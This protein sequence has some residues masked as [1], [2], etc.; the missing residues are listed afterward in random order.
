MNP[1]VYVIDGARTPYLKAREE[2]GPFSAADL[3]V[4]AGKELLIRQTSCRAI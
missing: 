1:K 3:A 4:A 2:P